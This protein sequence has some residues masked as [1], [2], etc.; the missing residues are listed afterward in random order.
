RGHHEAIVLSRESGDAHSRS[1]WQG[2]TLCVTLEIVRHLVFRRKLAA[3]GGE[4]HPREPV[5]AGRGE[6]AQRIPSQAP[7]I[8]DPLVGVENDEIEPSASQMI[9]NGKSCLAAADD[10]GANSLN[11]RNCPHIPPLALRAA[12]CRGRQSACDGAGSASGELTNPMR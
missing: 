6:E 9:A 1:H 3:A 10:D 5:V 2:E 4:P 8:T 12:D 11:F 7:R